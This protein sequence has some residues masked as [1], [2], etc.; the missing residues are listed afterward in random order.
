MLTVPLKAVHL[1]SGKSY[2]YV[3]GEGNMREVKWI[4]TGLFGDETVE[5]LSGLTE[6][7]K[8]IIK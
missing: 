2:V 1:A 8:V 6:G 7:E 5:I 3:L 4:E